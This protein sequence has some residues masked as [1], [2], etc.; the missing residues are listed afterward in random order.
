MSDCEGQDVEECDFYLFE[1]GN[2]IWQNTNA[3][4]KAS[5]ACPPL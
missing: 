1:H 3:I 4:H 5:P 2:K